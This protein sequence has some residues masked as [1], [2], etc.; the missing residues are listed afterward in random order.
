MNNAL[1]K[2]ITAHASEYPGMQPCDAVKLVYQAIFGGGH[3][4]QDAHLAYERLCDE[5]LGC[6]HDGTRMHT[7]VLGDFARI[8]ID[9]ELSERELRMISRIFCAS[10]KRHCAGYADADVKIRKRFR[11]ALELLVDMSKKHI[12]GFG[13]DELEGYI[14]KYRDDGYPAVSHSDTYRS[15]YSPAYRVIDSRYIRLLP[16]LLHLDEL[17]DFSSRT[18]LAIDGRCA[19][20]KSTAAMLIC[21]I[22]DGDTVHMDDFFLP[23]ELRSAERLAE[24]GGNLHRERFIEEVIPHL[25]DMREFTYRSFM[26]GSA[27][28]YADVPRTVRPAEIIVCEGS[29]ALHPEFG[30]YY[31]MAIFSDVDPDEQLHRIYER[32]GEYLLK[33]FINE[34]IP[35]E[36]R[37]FERFSI[38]RRCDYVV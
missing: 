3:M 34:W 15:A 19:S 32:D 33:R 24:D 35:M 37:Y 25:R 27:A 11:D 18:V 23:P 22:F 6:K 36:E 20:G 9:C 8:Y 21:D 31:D 29:Y 28:T 10:A 1:K 17:T 4:V 38:R 30:N 14:A 13:H 7:E 5:Y 26:C 16:C 2:I 12:F